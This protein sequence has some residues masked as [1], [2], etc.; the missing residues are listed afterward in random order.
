MAERV[1]HMN[2]GKLMPWP[3]CERGER[4]RRPRFFTALGGSV[5]VDGQKGHW[6]VQRG[7]QLPG[8]TEKALPT[9]MKQRARTARRS[10]GGAANSSVCDAHSAYAPEYEWQMAVVSPI[11]GTPRLA[12]SQTLC[13][14]ISSSLSIR[15]FPPGG[16]YEQLSTS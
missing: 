15:S 16:D 5:C 7:I 4:L 11:L 14:C 9:V 1:S 8:A 12:S 2:Q 13:F 6:T 10:L 3:M